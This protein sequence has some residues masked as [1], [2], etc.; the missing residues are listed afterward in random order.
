MKKT[1][2]LIMGAA[3]GG[4]TAQLARADDWDQKTVFTFSVPVEIPDQVLPAG[5]YVFKLADSPSNRN[6]VQ[7]FNEAQNHLY[8][9]FLAIP[10]YRL[11]VT[12]KTVITFDERP[13]GSPEAVKAWFY[14]GEHYGHDF[15]YPK[16]KP[17]ELAQADERPASP[18]PAEPES[19]A[20]NQ[21][22]PISAGL[23]STPPTQAAEPE[24]VGVVEIE[25]TT[26]E[27]ES[28]ASATE[29]L[30][31]TASLLPLIGILGLLSLGGAI[32]L[33]LARG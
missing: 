17:V 31:Q 1:L 29:R 3:L 22:P 15:V 20:G 14:P 13:A 16:V 6:I 33:R 10:D 11:D 19:R 7:V 9:T 12:D 18:T 5:T 30:P 27:F 4:A 32:S 26:I 25:T 21:E 23:A 8:G 24:T 28:P 2:L